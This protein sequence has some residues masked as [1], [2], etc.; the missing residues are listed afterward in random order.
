MHCGMPSEELRADLVT[1]V[2]VV[3]QKGAALA[4]ASEVLRADLMRDRLGGRSA[5]GYALMGASEEQKG[6]H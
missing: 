6:T 3:Q 2:T 4:D 1:V 5:E